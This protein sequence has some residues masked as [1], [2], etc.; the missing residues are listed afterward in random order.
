[1]SWC[2]LGNW[3]KINGISNGKRHL[4]IGQSDILFWFV[5]IVSK[6]LQVSMMPYVV[7][8]FR[9]SQYHSLFSAIELKQVINGPVDGKKAL[10][11][12]WDRSDSR[13]TKIRCFIKVDHLSNWSSLT[14]S[15]LRTESKL[16][17]LCTSLAIPRAPLTTCSSFQFL[18]RNGLESTIKACFPAS[19][20]T[21]IYEICLS[22]NDRTVMEHGA[23]VSFSRLLQDLPSMLLSSPMDSINI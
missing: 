13:A 17:R 21:R 6:S 23:H 10:W 9:Y 22:L 4:F 19:Y 15:H 16:K 1:M 11:R 18:A 2:P 20:T 12:T 3:Y 5:V 7:K 8:I 14:R